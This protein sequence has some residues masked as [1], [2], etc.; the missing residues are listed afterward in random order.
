MAGRRGSVI[1]GPLRGRRVCSGP[2]DFFLRQYL[3][4][5]V[6]FVN[7]YK[8]EL[9]KMFDLQKFGM[10]FG[11]EGMRNIL[12]KL[13]N[14]HRKLK[15]VHLA[16]TN[17]K[18][19]VGVML[20]SLLSGAGYRVGLYTSPHLVTFR[21]RIRIG[22]EMISEDKVLAL[23]EKVWAAVSLDFPP[24]F[25]EFV[26]ALAFLYFAS[27]S[28][29]LAIIETGLGGRLDSTNVIEPL[30]TAITNVTLEHTDYLGHT[31]AEIAAEKAG[32]IKAGVPVAGGRLSP[33]ARAV[34]EA[35]AKEQGSP[36]W[37]LGRDFKVEPVSQDAQGRLTVNYRRGSAAYDQLALTLAGPHQADNAAVALTLALALTE[38][39][40][41]LSEDDLRQGLKKA[42]WPGRAEIYPA[43]GWPPEGAGALAPLMLDGAHN[44]AG[45]QALAEMLKG[46]GR[47]KLHV[48][49]GVMADK[50]IGGVLGPILAQADRIYLT[51]PVFSRAASPELLREKIVAS[52]GQ[53]KAPTSLH[54]GIPQALRAAADE[55]AEGDLVLLS[56]SLFTVGECRAYLEGAPE[57]ESN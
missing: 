18:G 56:G 27:E 53:P 30:L 47:R 44:P 12:E 29:D 39:G 15:L 55:A 3:W 54:P 45:A 1:A 33:E 38:K 50:D 2:G 19:S 20:Q 43:G 13:D 5:W 14:P 26:T 46:L 24:T 57:V 16:G 49:V 17:G 4:C 36:F 25:F 11:L 32:I 8:R 41:N 52:L 10:K 22:P 21:E 6:C 7:S 42:V 34:I 31:V 35:R 37:L 9:Q 23:S 48:V 40:F 51:R 28:L